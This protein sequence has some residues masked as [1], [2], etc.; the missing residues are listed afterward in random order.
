MLER[1]GKVNGQFTRPLSMVGRNPVSI[2][3]GG[4][5]RMLLLLYVPFASLICLFELTNFSIALF[6]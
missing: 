5:L 1:R 2:S 3:T 6:N 4:V